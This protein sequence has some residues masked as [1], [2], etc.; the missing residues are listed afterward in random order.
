MGVSGPP[1]R[2]Q[3]CAYLPTDTDT[4]HGH[5]P[6]IHPATPHPLTCQ[7]R[8]RNF[9]GATSRCHLHRG[10]RPHAW[11]GN[12]CLSLWNN[13]KQKET[14]AQG[15]CSADAGRQAG[16]LLPIHDIVPHVRQWSSGLPPTSAWDLVLSHM[17]HFACVV[18]C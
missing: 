7:N 12:I 14:P 13:L 4:P 3:C 5:Q 9:T 11:H 17:L 18:A 15:A 8:W 10:M 1:P 16:W 2:L 6:H